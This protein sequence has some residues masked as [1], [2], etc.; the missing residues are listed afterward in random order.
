LLA[1]MCIGNVEE[2]EKL[3]MSIISATE[4]DH[5]AVEIQLEAQNNC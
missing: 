1:N 5:T 4:L 3:T 2:F